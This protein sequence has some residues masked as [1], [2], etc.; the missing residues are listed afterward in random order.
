M[1]AT[2]LKFRK[3]GKKDWQ[4]N[5]GGYE[6][7]KAEIRGD[8][9]DINKLIRVVYYISEGSHDLGDAATL[10][11]AVKMAEDHWESRN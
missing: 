5:A 4:A 1:F 6:I 8:C 10:K 3:V 7:Y 2:P 11:A 9:M